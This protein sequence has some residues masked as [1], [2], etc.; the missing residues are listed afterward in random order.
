MPDVNTPLAPIYTLHKSSFNVKEALYGAKGDGTT[1]DTTAIQAAIADA[2]SNNKG[3]VYL[4]EGTYIVSS[5]LTITSSG[6]SVVGAGTGATIIKPS[7]SF[8]GV[9]VINGTGANACAIKDLSIQGISTTY[10]S[11]PSAD[12]IRLNHCSYWRLENLFFQYLNGYGVQIISDATADSYYPILDNIHTKTC[13]SGI[14][15]VGSASSDYGMGAFLTNINVENCQAGDGLAI[16][17]VSDVLVNGLEGN[18]VATGYGLHI[19]GACT[20]VAVNGFDIGAL[21]SAAASPTATC[22]VESSTHGSP[23]QVLFSG[24]I[25]KDG[26]VGASVTAGSLVRFQ[27]C[28]FISN[29]T[30][31]LSVSGTAQANVDDC[32]FYLNGFTA[33]ANHFDLSSTTS[34]ETKVTNCYFNTPQGSSSGQVASAMR[35]TTGVVEV[36]DCRFAGAAAFVSTFPTWAKNNP[37]YNPVGA[38]TPPSIPTSTTPLTNP[39]SVDCTVHITGGTVS[40][41]AIGGTATGLTSGT[42]R[43]PCYQTITLT[44]SVAPTWTWFGD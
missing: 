23:T 36:S 32:D 31:G 41:I 11:N 40:A 26:L 13:K 17:D 7:A 1:D 29:G 10:S 30:I 5:P 6:I 15:L 25:F 42:F 43:V 39:F 19:K 8:S 18:A 9:A 38:L 27:G 4:P 37:G 34:V 44:Y 2:V 21:V 24:G 16:I 3:V 14:G 12:G 20:N 33:G 28:Q 35:C 22:L